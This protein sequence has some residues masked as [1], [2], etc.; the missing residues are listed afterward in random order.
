MPK[1]EHLALTETMYAIAIK[2]IAISML[3]LYFK[4]EKE[5]LKLKENYEV[6]S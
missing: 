3:G 2:N 6:V 4:D 5:L 1:E